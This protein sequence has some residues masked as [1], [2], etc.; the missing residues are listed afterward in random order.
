MVS[1]DA[2]KA[3]AS[4]GDAWLAVGG[5]VYDVTAFLDK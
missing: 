3:H 4:P 5:R 1:L 2:L